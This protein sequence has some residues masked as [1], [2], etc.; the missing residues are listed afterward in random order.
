MQIHKNIKQTKQ[1]N[2]NIKFLFFGKCPFGDDS[3][4]N[5]DF[6]L[7]VPARVEV[8]RQNLPR[9]KMHKIQSSFDK[10]YKIVLELEKKLLF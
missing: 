3:G 7:P 2:V 6:I 9:Q 8:T 10:T 5:L 1:K 4:Y